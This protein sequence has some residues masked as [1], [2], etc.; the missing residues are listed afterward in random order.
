VQQAV[1]GFRL[2]YGADPEGVWAAPGRVNLIGEHTDYNGG[3]CL[4]VALPYRTVMAAARTRD[5][6]LHLRSAQL[7]QQPYDGSLHDVGPGSPPGW[8]A[9]VAG[10]PW[11]LGSTAQGHDPVW[12]AFGLRG[13]VDSDVPNG[14]GLSSSAALSCSAALAVDDLAGLGLGDDDTGRARLAEAC[15][16]AENQV[17]G[18]PTGGMDQSASLRCTAGHALLLD[19]RDGLDP[20]ESV[21]QVPFDP[22]THGLRLLVIDTQAPH[23]LVDGQYAARRGT[24][25][26]AARLLGVSTLRAVADRPVEQV[27][28][29]LTD[30]EQRRR[31]RH[32]LSEIARVQQTVALLEQGRVAEIGLLLNASH[33][34][35]RDDYEVSCHELDLAVE[36]ALDA[37]ALGARMTGGGFGGSAIALVPDGGVDAVSRAVARAYAAEGL[38]P[39]RFADGQPAEAGRRLA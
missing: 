11:A 3:L 9:Y 39:P 23:A 28:A 37:G 33:A 16:R 29:A 31:V 2:A 4:P 17:A 26:Q 27:L 34:S 38:H 19:C 7:P 24:C 1:T 30:D 25:E 13:Y 5:G 12:D 35:L 22:V 10:V 15:V 14:A 20:A 32:V 21:R 8:A 18:A 6:A 36:S